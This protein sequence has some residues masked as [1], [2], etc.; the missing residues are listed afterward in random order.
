MPT[1]EEVWQVYLATIGSLL[2]ASGSDNTNEI[3]ASSS[4][5]SLRPPSVKQ[6]ELGLP[7]IVSTT[8]HP[9]LRSPRSKHKVYLLYLHWT[10]LVASWGYRVPRSHGGLDKESV[11]P[12]LISGYLT[13]LDL[14]NTGLA[15][16]P[17]WLGQLKALNCLILRENPLAEFP[18]VLCRSLGRKL[19]ELNL[20]TTGLRSLPTE[21][22]YLVNLR[23]LHID[24][25]NLGRLPRQ[26][27]RLRRLTLLQ[28]SHNRIT[29][30]PSDIGLCRQLDILFLEGN[31]IRLLPFSITHL[32]LVC[33]I[34]PHRVGL[35]RLNSWTDAQLTLWREQQS[36]VFLSQYFLCRKYQNAPAVPSPRSLVQSERYCERTWMTVIKTR[37]EILTTSGMVP[38]SAVVDIA[39]RMQ[40]CPYT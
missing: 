2:F 33:W 31:P 13:I 18:G 28:A 19:T 7:I 29:H 26:I 35:Q 6:C 10:R 24:R 11:C 34:F 20:S 14:T 5:L 39:R 21:I 37:A 9:D 38:W 15:R 30:L 1:M 8:S 3:C 32:A 25:N 17:P 23:G 4:Y 27:G 22:G 40:S 12:V 16:V 36:V